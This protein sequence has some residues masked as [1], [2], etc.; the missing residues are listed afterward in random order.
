[1]LILQ[2]YDAVIRW[3]VLCALEPNCMAPTRDLS[4]RFNGRDHYANCHRFDQSAL[5]ILLGNYFDNDFA[6]YSA[7][8]DVLGVMRGSSNME[9]LRVCLSGDSVP[10]SIKSKSYF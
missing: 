6:K 4:C 8:N 5:S 2:L 3:W 9:Q 10:L 1:M 7:K